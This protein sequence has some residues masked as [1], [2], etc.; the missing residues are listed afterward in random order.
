M[1]G[2]GWGATAT[3]VDG[4]PAKAEA[5]CGPELLAGWLGVEVA[6]FCS[7]VLGG[8]NSVRTCS[9]SPLVHVTTCALERSSA[10]CARTLGSSRSA[11]LASL[12]TGMLCGVGR[13]SGWC[14]ESRRQ[15]KRKGGV[16]CRSAALPAQR[17]REK[18][19]DPEGKQDMQRHREPEA[20]LEHPAIF[21][22]SFCSHRVELE[23]LLERG[24]VAPLL[25]NRHE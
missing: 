13:V 21:L 3:R 2:R 7:A 19:R 16:K 11:S 4:R 14:H 17:A 18:A 1:G 15:N 12:G 9:A 20:V 22:P 5:R 23:D 24:Q 8:G 6:P 25:D 10:S